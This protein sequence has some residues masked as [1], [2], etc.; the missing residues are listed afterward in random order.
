MCSHLS[1]MKA[2]MLKFTV[3]LIWQCLTEQ[4][5]TADM[6]V[7]PAF[8]EVIPTGGAIWDCRTGSL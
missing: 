8:G 2:A 6:R 1:W 3:E 5:L 4:G 7:L